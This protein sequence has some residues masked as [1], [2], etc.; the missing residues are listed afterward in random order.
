MEILFLVILVASLVAILGLVVCCSHLN[1]KNIELIKEN[2]ELSGYLYRARAKAV[3]LSEA[4][5]NATK[6]QE[7]K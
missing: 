4:L 6:E 3:F 1:T 7:N 2:Q 5:T